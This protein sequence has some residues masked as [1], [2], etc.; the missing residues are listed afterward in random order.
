MHPVIQ[1][2]YD[3]LIM[4]EEAVRVE[5]DVAKFPDDWLM[6]HRWGKGRK[7]KKTPNGYILDHITVGENKLL[8]SRVTEANKSRDSNNN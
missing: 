4:C 2:L 7:E 3:S 8:L 6:L 5:G 1:Q